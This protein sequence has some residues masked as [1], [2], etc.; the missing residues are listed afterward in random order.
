MLPIGRYNL[1][2]ELQGFGPFNRALQVSA[3][4]RVRVDAQLAVGTLSETVSITAQAPIIQPDSATVGALLPEKAVQDL[5][6][7]GRNVIGLVRLV[8]GAN[9]GLPNSLSSGNRPTIAVRPPP[10]R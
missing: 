6:L 9:E 2:I 10:C 3:G 5:P 1:A 8:P 4:D 7:N